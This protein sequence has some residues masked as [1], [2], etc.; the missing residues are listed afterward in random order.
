MTLIFLSGCATGSNSDS[1]RSNKESAYPNLESNKPVGSKNRVIDYASIQRLLGLDRSFDQLGYSEKSFETCQVGFG[2][3]NNTEC[4]RKYFIVLHFKL[5][6]RDSEGTISTV[7]TDADLKAIAGQAVIWSL[8]NANGKVVTD[9]EGYGQIVTTAFESQKNQR[10]RLAVGSDFLLT[11]A[12]ETRRL[13][14]PK[15][16]C[17]F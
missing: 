8:K 7:L 16:W 11:K 2:Y 6:C 14:A 15:S 9:S 4:Q 17:K 3:A 1:I 13:I 10:L 5:V 12:G